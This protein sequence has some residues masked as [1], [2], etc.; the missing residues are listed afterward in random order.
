MY[1]ILSNVGILC[2][3]E[4][5][6]TITENYLIYFNSV[7]NSK[8]VFNDFSTEKYVQIFFSAGRLS[9]LDRDTNTMLI[10]FFKNLTR[11]VPNIDRLLIY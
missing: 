7:D 3:F 1:I 4:I 5:S 2:M 9:A 10:H 8:L 11:E 6:I